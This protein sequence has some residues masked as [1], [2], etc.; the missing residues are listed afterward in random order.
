MKKLQRYFSVHQTPPRWGVIPNLPPSVRVD[1]ALDHGQAGRKHIEL[2]AAA[3]FGRVLKG[4][5]KAA[6][7]TWGTVETV[8]WLT[9]L[10][11]FLETP[12]PPVYGRVVTPDLPHGL[13]NPHPVRQALEEWIPTPWLVGGS[14]DA[15]WSPL[16]NT[17][18]LSNGSML[19]FVSSNQ[20][21]LSQAGA[22]G[23]SFIWFDEELP[24]FIWTENKAR[25][26]RP[27]AA[28]WMTYVPTG[29]Y[30]WMEPWS[31]AIA[32]G[33]EP[34]IAYRH[35]DMYDNL[36]NL[37]GGFAHGLEWIANWTA[38]MEPTELERRVWGRD[39]RPTG[40]V[41]GFKIPETSIGPD[42]F[43]FRTVR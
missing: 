24:E 41:Y 40:L 2:H 3:Q 12:D 26:D 43:D 21:A 8:C 13:R 11:P 32:K 5:N 14:W 18:R 4:S 36:H 27:G 29:R 19:E 9:G 37:P 22:Y 10:H 35:V 6:K 15:A 25:L 30:Y 16:G 34:A 1:L 23:V 28:W 33:A 42:D 39:A 20:D 17:L 38:G 7:T 31:A